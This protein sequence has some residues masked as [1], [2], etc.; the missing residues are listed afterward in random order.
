MRSALGVLV[1]ASRSL[2]FHGPPLRPVQRMS[3][4][5]PLASSKMPEVPE[6]LQ[7]PGLKVSQND[8]SGQRE[9]KRLLVG[10]GDGVEVASDVAVCLRRL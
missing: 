1:I 10:T 4:L 9:R 7:E 8:T 2:G 6:A 5:Q 3:L